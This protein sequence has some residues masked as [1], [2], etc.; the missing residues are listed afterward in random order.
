M[1]VPEFQPRL[2]DP[3]YF[4]CHPIKVGIILC[5]LKMRKLRHMEIFKYLA[6]G[7]LAGK[8]MR[9]KANRG[10]LSVRRTR[11]LGHKRCHFQTASDSPAS[12]GPGSQEAQPL[13]NLGG[14][15]R[16]PIPRCESNVSEHRLC[17]ARRRQIRTRLQESGPGPGS[18]VLRR[19][20][21]GAEAAGGIPG[22]TCRAAGRRGADDLPGAAG[23]GRCL[24]RF[25]SQQTPGRASFDLQTHRL[26][27]PKEEAVCPSGWRPSGP[28]PQLWVCFPNR[29]SSSVLLPPHYRP[30]KLPQALHCWFNH[31]LL[32]GKNADPIP[33][34]GPG[35]CRS[36][37]AFS[38]LMG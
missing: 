33:L 24:T 27:T 22:P 32:R 20:G 19:D 15:P 11:G 14:F 2:S 21:A 6:Q 30:P 36:N 28:S 8:W 10:L 26:R 23:R 18:T 31:L 5:I 16:P 38:L 37:V 13:P 17:S 12:F 4:S 7:H 29:F 34:K 25:G 9:Q 35:V 1:S 3:M